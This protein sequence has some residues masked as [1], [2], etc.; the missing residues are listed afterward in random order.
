MKNLGSLNLVF[1]VSQRKQCP[2]LKLKKDEELQARTQFRIY[3]RSM[4]MQN[5]WTVSTVMQK[6]YFLHY[7]R[8]VHKVRGICSILLMSLFINI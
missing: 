1:P 8:A 3:V 4:P 2:F 5:L 7:T 6:L